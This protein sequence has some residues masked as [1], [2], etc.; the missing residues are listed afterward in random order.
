MPD[1]RRLA[2][3]VHTRGQALGQPELGVDPP[4]QDQATVRAGVG[5][6]ERGDDRLAFRLESERDLRYTGCGHRASS[7]ECLEAS[8]HRFYSTCEWLRGSC[9]LF[10]ADNLGLRDRERGVE[11]K[12]GG[13]G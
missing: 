8:R 9:L 5:D 11:G 12:R 3:V 2:L 6:V 7:F 1:F 13:F 10:F 4:Q